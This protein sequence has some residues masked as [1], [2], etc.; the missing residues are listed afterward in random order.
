MEEIV[1][2]QAQEHAGSWW[3][4]RHGRLAELR[5]PEAGV[6]A[7]AGDVKNGEGTISHVSER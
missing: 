1:P 4:G 3:A 5:K 6:E 2:T 7:L